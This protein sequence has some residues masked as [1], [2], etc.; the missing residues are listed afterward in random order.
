MRTS[1][2]PVITWGV[3]HFSGLTNSAA[4]GT[5]SPIAMHI[6]A[7]MSPEPENQNEKQL[8]AVSQTNNASIEA[9]K[10]AAARQ[11]LLM[12]FEGHGEIS[13]VPRAIADTSHP[14]I[15]QEF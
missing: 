12:S 15:S 10:D 11:L 8:D 3:L 7:S 4:Y 13:R 6:A 2:R 9:I 1:P 5:L 14:A